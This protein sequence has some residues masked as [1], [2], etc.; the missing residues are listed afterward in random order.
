MND[1]R[2]GAATMIHTNLPKRLNSPP[3]PSNPLLVPLIISTMLPQLYFF[4]KFYSPKSSELTSPI[5]H[6]A[7]LSMF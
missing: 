3:P 4:D 5:G 1:R 2:E 7:V 6:N